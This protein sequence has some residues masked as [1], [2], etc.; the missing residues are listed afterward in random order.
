MVLHCKEVHSV[1]VN[2]YFPLSILAVCFTLSPTLPA[3]R[4]TDGVLR[5]AN[6]SEYGLASGVFTK[7][8]NKVGCSV[9][10]C[11]EFG[12]RKFVINFVIL[13]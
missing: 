11:I 13:D 4:D 1:V 9:K 10:F 8:I 5:R 3:Y 2:H 12:P 7:D 6:A